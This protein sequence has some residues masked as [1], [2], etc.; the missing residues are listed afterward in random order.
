MGLVLT[1]LWNAFVPGHSIEVHVLQCFCWLDGG[2]PRERVSSLAAALAAAI[3]IRSNPSQSCLR[4]LPIGTAV[5]GLTYRI[6]RH[7]PGVADMVMDVL[8]TIARQLRG[9]GS[10]RGLLLLGSPGKGKTTLL[11][12]VARRLADP[13]ARGGLGLRVIVVGGVVRGALEGVCGLMAG[14]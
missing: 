1:R 3:R 12:D 8:S 2:S 10:A 6:G 7:M 4:A 14:G 9:E 13:P 11:R 5:L